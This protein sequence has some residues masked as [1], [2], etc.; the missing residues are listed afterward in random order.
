MN[1]EEET[2]CC[3]NCCSWVILARTGDYTANCLSDC[4]PVIVFFFFKPR[5]GSISLLSCLA[6]DLVCDY[7]ATG[8]LGFFKAEKDWR[9]VRF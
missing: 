1:F 6:A 2:E 4:L 9:L 7:R 8:L 3:E 5:Y